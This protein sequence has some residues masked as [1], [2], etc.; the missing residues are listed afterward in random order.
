MFWTSIINIC[1]EKQACETS[2]FGPITITSKY[3][4]TTCPS[5]RKWL[6]VR[7]WTVV[8]GWSCKASGLQIPAQ[9]ASFDR[10]GPWEQS[11]GNFITSFTFLSPRYRLKIS[12]ASSIIMFYVM[13]ICLTEDPFSKVEQCFTG[14][15]TS[16]LAVSMRLKRDTS[17]CWWAYFFIS[18]K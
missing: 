12:L 5:F 2:D 6:S 13:S 16:P 9:Q 18:L 8:V 10:L 14:P 1:H 3:F 11:Q 7:T 17:P 15:E 4:K